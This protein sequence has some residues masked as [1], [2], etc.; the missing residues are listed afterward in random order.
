M[1]A[2]AAAGGVLLSAVWLFIP[3]DPVIQLIVSVPAVRLA[4]LVG[5]WRTGGARLARVPWAAAVYLLALAVVLALAYQA[6]AV[7][8]HAGGH[9]GGPMDWGTGPMPHHAPQAMSVDRLTGP[10]DKTPDARFTLTAARGK[11]RLG[12]GREI[13]ALTFNGQAP[14][15]ELR[16]RLGS[17][18]EVT[19][20]NT[21]VEEGV[22]LHWHGVDVPNAEDGVPGVT[23]EAV[24][25]GGR[26]ARP[27]P[28]GSR[29][30]SGWS[31]ARR[32]RT[33]STSAARRTP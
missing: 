9:H 20:I 22:T 14:G 2:H 6:N 27:S 13:D 1:S 17:L 12:S 26:P 4:A 24:I 31:T 5:R 25:P 16:V 7:A 30:C 15:P 19:L 18:V 21:D 32:S 23:Q 33:A 3:F 8:A 29:C 11:I 28:Q 10:R